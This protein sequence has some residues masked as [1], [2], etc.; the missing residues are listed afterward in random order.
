MMQMTNKR[1][2]L[3]GLA[4]IV[5]SNAIALGGVAYNRAGEPTSSLTLTERELSLPHNYGFAAE[6]SGISLQLRW[7][8]F[9][10]KKTSDYYSRWIPTEWL[11]A[12]KLKSLGYEVSYPLNKPDSHEHYQKALS[13]E[14]FLVLENDGATY[15]KV[16]QQRRDALAEA[17]R[18]QQQNPDKEE[19][20]GRL[21]TATAGMEAEQQ[22]NSRLFVIDAGLD[23]ETLRRQYSDNSQ[24][25]IA[26]GQVRLRYHG[27]Y[28]K[29]PYLKG[30][31]QQLSVTKVNVPLQHT[32]ALTPLLDKTYRRKGKQSP[33]YEVSLQYGLRYEPWVMSVKGL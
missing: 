8:V 20:K 2:L 23:Y 22:D 31:I 15:Q 16:L 29:Q 27:N 14:V 18:L 1:T 28:S 26:K 3:T 24:Y 13:K 10:S 5:L 4:I 21:K 17:Q 11:D 30:A 25:L 6:N 32:G 9:D 7:R 12:D 33:R 19:F